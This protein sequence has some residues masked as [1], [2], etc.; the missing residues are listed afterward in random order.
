MFCTRFQGERGN[1]RDSINFYANRSLSTALTPTPLFGAAHNDP[2]VAGI[3]HHYQY[4]LSDHISNPHFQS[5]EQKHDSTQ[6]TVISD[7]TVEVQKRLSYI[8]VICILPRRD[9]R[10][11]ANLFAILLIPREVTLNMLRVQFVAQPKVAQPLRS[12]PRLRGRIYTA[13]RSI[14]MIS[15][16]AVARCSC[17]QEGKRRSLASKVRESQAHGKERTGLS[18]N[19]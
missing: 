12:R 2:V 11:Q 17:V 9:L 5:P 15:L 14:C 4:P 7:R 19:T 13:S 3:H 10:C 8:Q 18:K 6:P 16:A 1:S